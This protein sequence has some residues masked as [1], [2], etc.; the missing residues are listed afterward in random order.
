MAL[1]VIP[2]PSEWDFKVSDINNIMNNIETFGL[3]F[4]IDSV[5]GVIL[6]MTVRYVVGDAVGSDREKN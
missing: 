1:Y 4:L 2:K 3:V 6:G 5:I